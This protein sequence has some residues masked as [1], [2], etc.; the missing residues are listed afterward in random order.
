MRELQLDCVPCFLRAAIR[1]CQDCN[2]PRETTEE[3]L[4][5][6]LRMMADSDWKQP[7]IN[8]A[9]SM[10]EIIRTRLGCDPYREAKKESNRAV[11]ACTDSIRT[12]IG[13]SAEPLEHA[14]RMATAANCIDFGITTE[15][16]IPA[17][18]EQALTVPYAHSDYALLLAD[19][20]R[21]N[22]KEHGG[23][24][25]YF[26]DNCG[27]S[28]FDMFAIEVLLKRFP[29]LRVAYVVKGGPI[30]NDTTLEEAREIGFAE[31]PRVEL[32]AIGNGVAGSGPDRLS[33]EVQGWI[34]DADVTISKGQGNYEALGDCKGI[35]FL[36]KLKC[37]SIAAFA[38][39]T[40]NSL[41][42]LY[43]Q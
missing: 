19:C 30:I 28:V 32:R 43:Q 40:L 12:Q 2:V 13:A 3:V 6:V 7:P 37:P 21:A 14:L 11:L 42:L 18:V 22:A 27:E 10:H 38:G 16:S 39:H 41:I 34:A 8:L 4:R 33:P 20:E 24:V 35:Y 1:A 26:A 29:R 9:Q 15:Y 31:M 36:L 5:D 25:L 23:L 17:I